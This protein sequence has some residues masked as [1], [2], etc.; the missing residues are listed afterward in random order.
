MTAALLIHPHEA[1]PGGRPRRPAGAPAADASEAR[2][3]ASR[4]SLDDQLL[5]LLRGDRDG[6][7]VC[8]ERAHVQ[9]S[10]AECP[11]CGSTLASVPRP[12]D[13]QMALV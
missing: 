4:A 8:G 7:L 13:D 11:A 1:G 6:C 3:G 10:I 5:A 2:G 9:D 12:A